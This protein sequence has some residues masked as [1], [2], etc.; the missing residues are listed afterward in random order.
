MHRAK[1]T[2][3]WHTRRIVG[4]QRWEETEVSD[5]LNIFDNSD[6]RTPIVILQRAKDGKGRI[7]GTGES[8]SR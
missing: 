6:S 1:H 5:T 4:V 3:K 2:E 8:S 7:Q